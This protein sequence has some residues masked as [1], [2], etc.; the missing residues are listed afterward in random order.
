MKFS[1]N[2]ALP[3]L[4][5]LVILSVTVLVVLLSSSKTGQ[6]EIADNPDQRHIGLDGDMPEHTLNKLATDMAEFKDLLKGNKELVS[7]TTDEYDQLRREIKI[8]KE[9]DRKLTQ[10]LAEDKNHQRA[11]NREKIDV[12]V[13]A[14]QVLD[15]IKPELKADGPTRLTKAGLAHS[16]PVNDSTDVAQVSQATRRIRAQNVAQPVVPDKAKDLLPNFM[17]PPPLGTVGTQAG[18]SGQGITRQDHEPPPVPV[19]TIP[20]MS[21]LDGATTVTHLIGRVPI[22]GDVTD[23]A[24]FKIVLG[25]ENL[26]ANGHTVPGIE[27]MI[28]EGYVWGDATLS[29]VRAYINSASYIFQDGR[30]VSHR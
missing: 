12:S 7:R 5:G 30:I 26:A 28:M 20:D 24:P 19:H 14:Q 13:I 16:Y 17:Y 22:K 3:I 27:G 25:K 29:C 6:Q 8:L 10:Q 2:K 4:A 23:P 1:G 15:R 21:I 18:K 9:R 11:S